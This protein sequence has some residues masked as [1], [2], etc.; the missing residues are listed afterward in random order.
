MA[1][2]QEGKEIILFGTPDEI[3]VPEIRVRYN[4][5]KQHTKIKNSQG[6]YEFLLKVYGRNVSIQEQMI[7]LFLDNS[8]NILGYYKHTIGT[9]TA[10]LIDIP[11]ILGIALKSLA[12]NII[13]SHNHPSENV[14]PSESD[15]KITE[16]MSKAVKAVKLILLDHIIVTKNHGFYSFADNHLLS[17]LPKK[18]ISIEQQLRQEIFDQLQKVTPSNAPN[19]YRLIQT[20]SGY[21]NV[22]QRIINLVVRDRITPSACIPQIENEL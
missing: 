19:V 11:M 1:Q 21:R 16:H 2:Y 10:S 12:R 6:T 13:L 17:G 5:G 22:E 14:S 3:H 15:K 20:V 18:E 4:R 9:P 8:L 7:A